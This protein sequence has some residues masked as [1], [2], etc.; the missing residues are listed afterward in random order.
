MG[1]KKVLLVTNVQSNIQQD[2]TI[3]KAEALNKLF[4]VQIYMVAVDEYITGIAEMVKMASSPQLLFRFKDENGL[5]VVV[6]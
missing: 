1:G 5:L 2:M 4:G 6:D 3:P